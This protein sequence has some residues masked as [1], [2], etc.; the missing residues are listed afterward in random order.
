MTRFEPT[1]GVGLVLVGRVRQTVGDNSSQSFSVVSLCSTCGSFRARLLGPDSVSLSV[2][3]SV[4]AAVIELPPAIPGICLSR[5][6][7][8]RLVLGSDQFRD[9]IGL[10]D[11]NRLIAD[12]NNDK[13]PNL[14][15]MIPFPRVSCAVRAHL[16]PICRR[17]WKSGAY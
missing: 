4:S 10:S 15:R 3:L 9:R 13:R 5:Y 8:R 17:F 16:M 11:S 12:N 2:C 7:Q 14:I 1:A 6:W